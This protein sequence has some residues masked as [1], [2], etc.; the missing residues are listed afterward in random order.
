MSGVRKIA[1]IGSLAKSFS[2][3][4]DP[5]RDGA[6]LPSY[7]FPTRPQFWFFTQNACVCFHLTRSVPVKHEVSLYGLLLPSR[8]D[9]RP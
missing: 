3:P 2:N 7:W 8:Q 4:A 6:I 9:T 1:A 5:F